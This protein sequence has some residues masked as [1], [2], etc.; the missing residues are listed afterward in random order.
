M[1]WALSGTRSFFCSFSGT[2]VRKGWEPL[3]QI[4]KQ[5]GV[6]CQLLYSLLFGLN[7]SIC[8]HVH[9]SLIHLISVVHVNNKMSHGRKNVLWPVYK[10]IVHGHMPVKLY[11]CI[12]N[13]QFTAKC[14]YL[15]QNV[16]VH[17]RLA[18]KHRSCAYF[19][20]YITDIFSG[21]KTSV[22]KIP[23]ICL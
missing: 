23:D 1:L 22:K 10:R 16:R 20:P 19:F 18:V 13:I 6:F 4:N 14:P 8:M 12:I 5:N 2:G 9:N 11:F 21:E 3:L 15:R 17:G 7:P